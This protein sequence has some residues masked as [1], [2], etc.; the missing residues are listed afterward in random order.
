[1]TCIPS[2]WRYRRVHAISQ[3][4]SH[5]ERCG[6]NQESNKK[7]EQVVPSWASSCQSLGRN[8]T[9]EGESIGSVNRVVRITVNVTVL[10]ALLRVITLVIVVSTNNSSKLRCSTDLMIWK[11]VLFSCRLHWMRWP[12]WRHWDTLRHCLRIW[13]IYCRRSL[14]RRKWRNMSKFATEHLCYIATAKL[15]LI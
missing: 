2:D 1:M 5:S 13:R 8:Y 10:R 15:R 14:E 4:E 9:T 12:H 11:W 6:I 3:R 7:S